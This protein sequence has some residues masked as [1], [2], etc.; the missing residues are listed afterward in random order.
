LRRTDPNLPVP[1]FVFDPFIVRTNPIG[2][3]TLTMLEALLGKW[4][5]HAFANQTDLPPAPLLKQ[6]RLPLPE[7]P[8]LLRRLLF[9]LLATCT[10]LPHSRRRTIRIA[11]ELALPFSQISQTQ[12]CHRYFLRHH[13]DAIATTWAR[14]LARTLTHVWLSLLEPIAFRY[15]KRIVVPSNGTA[16]ELA[17]TYPA[18]TQG[19]ICVI[20]NPVDTQWFQREPGFSS[21]AVYRRFSIPDAAFVLSFCALGGF[22]RK[23][24]HIVLTAL[25][26]LRD[27]KI[28][29]LVI[30]G[31]GGE[32]REFL[33]IAKRLRIAENVHFAGFQQD[34]RPYLWSSHAFI[35]PSAY[36]TFSL[37]CFQAAA[38]GLPL[39]ATRFNGLEDF[40]IHGVNGWF[41][42]RNVQSVAA[43]IGEAAAHPENTLFLGRTAQ[44]QVQAYRSE[45]FRSRWLAFLDRE[46][47]IRCAK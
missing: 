21:A 35:F 3:C 47:G 27:L 15:A 46:F 43:A 40:L 36:E 11:T 25:G 7:R 32:I 9:P 26:K 31:R 34:T 18:I 41:V 19:K 10:Y 37:A 33:A 13:R 8:E 29:L 24:L 1:L 39:I 44:Q 5:I 17:S 6:T 16:R 2:S 30:G 20:P 42:E 38:A 45:I 12:F 14:R 22:T 4:P 28:H 23:G